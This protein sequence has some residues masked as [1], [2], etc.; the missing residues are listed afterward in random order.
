ME[1]LMKNQLPFS[2]ILLDIDYFKK[3]NDTFGH[4]VGDEVL[5]FLASKLNTLS[6]IN[7]LCFRYGGEEFGII[8]K[9]EDLDCA[10]HIAER[11][12]KEIEE[13]V[14]P[15]GEPITLSLGIAF[16]EIGHDLNVAE[17]INK[18]DQALYRSKVQGRNRT[19]IYSKK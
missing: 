13:L 7:D 12:R 18:A 16:H 14:S 5:I 8:V 15:T 10:F 17:I 6:R 3:V 2:L 9:S 19:T 4:L 11:I 1:S